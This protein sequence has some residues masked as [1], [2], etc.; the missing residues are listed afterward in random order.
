MWDPWKAAVFDGYVTKVSSRLARDVGAGLPNVLTMLNQARHELR[1]RT[2]GPLTVAV[3][4]GGVFD[5]FDEV[6]NVQE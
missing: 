2:V 1:L 6:R 4:Q 3:N 5:Y